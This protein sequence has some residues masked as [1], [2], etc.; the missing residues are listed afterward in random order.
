MHIS[1]IAARV[2]QTHRRV[3]GA[4]KPPPAENPV[5]SS[6]LAGQS[7]LLAAERADRQARAVRARASHVISPSGRAIPT[8]GEIPQPPPGPYRDWLLAEDS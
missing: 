1:R 7:R 6:V 3:F 8:T 5:L 2:E 4:P